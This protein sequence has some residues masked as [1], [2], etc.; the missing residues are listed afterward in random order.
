[1]RTDKWTSIWVLE[2]NAPWNWS[3]TLTTNTHFSQESIDCSKNYQLLLVLKNLFSALM[4]VSVI[5]SKISMNL[6]NLR[7]LLKSITIPTTDLIKFFMSWFGVIHVVKENHSTLQ[8]MNMI[9]SKEKMYFSSYL[10]QQIFIR[11]S[12][13]LLC[14]KWSDDDCE[15]SWTPCWRFRAKRFNNNSILLLGLWWKWQQI[16]DNSHD[17]KQRAGAKDPEPNR[18]KR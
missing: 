16:I 1:M 7:N 11:K 17:E 3:K 14:L 4:E 15:K 10:E 18:R 13:Y 12:Q 2:M 6:I 8:T 9:T 5:H